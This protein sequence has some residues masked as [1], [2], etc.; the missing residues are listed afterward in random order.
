[1]IPSM[2]IRMITGL[3]GWI[4][5]CTYID[6]IITLWPQTG[7]CRIGSRGIIIT[8]LL[9]VFRKK[10]RRGRIKV[11]KRAI[12]NQFI[13]YRERCQTDTARTHIG[14]LYRIIGYNIYINGLGCFGSAGP[15]IGKSRW[16]GMSRKLDHSGHG[17]VI[18]R[19]RCIGRWNT[20]YCNGG[21]SGAISTQISIGRSIGR[22]PGHNSGRIGGGC[23]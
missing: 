18:C 10:G 5:P 19:Y 17:T 21:A 4:V 23:R 2:K 1:M 12:S 13:G 9:G 15:L 7:Q 6:G 14:N 3:W 8:L 20:G 22:G 16:T 11:C